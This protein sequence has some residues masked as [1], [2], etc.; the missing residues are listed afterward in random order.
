ML[1]FQHVGARGIAERHEAGA[2]HRWRI[3]APAGVPVEPRVPLQPPGP[4]LGGRIVLPFIR[5]ERAAAGSRT[6]MRK[7]RFWMAGLADDASV[8]AARGQDECQFTI[9]QQVQLE[10]RIAMARSDRARFRPR[11]SG[12]FMS[13]SVSGRPATGKRP[14]ASSL[15]RN[16][17]RRYSMCMRAGSRV[18]SAFQAIRSFGASVRQADS[19]RIARDPDQVVRTAHL[20]RAAHLRAVQI[21]LR[22]HDVVQNIEL[23]LG[24]EQLQFACLGEIGLGANS[25]RLASRSSPSRAMAA[26]AIVS[27]VPPRQ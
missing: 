10:D 3:D 13:L 17:R 11:T 25:D 15:S 16:S 6:R 21:A 19:S 18:P 23:V 14:S 1:I 26:A 8:V 12:A 22:L 7:C 24:D 20:E 2:T 5:T 27:N 9:V 4:I